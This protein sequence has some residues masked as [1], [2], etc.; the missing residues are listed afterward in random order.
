MTQSNFSKLCSILILNGLSLSKAPLKMK[1]SGSDKTISNIT[2]TTLKFLHVTLLLFLIKS[3][4]P[5]HVNPEAAKLATSAVVKVFGSITLPVI[6]T[7]H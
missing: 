5:F 3:L 2:S 6:P 4:K 7:K 1:S